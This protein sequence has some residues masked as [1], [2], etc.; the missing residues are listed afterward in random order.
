[1][2]NKSLQILAFWVAIDYDIGVCY[3]A[4]IMLKRILA[5]MVAAF[6]VSQ[7]MAED[8]QLFFGVNL[9]SS[10]LSISPPLANT[11][12]ESTP[13]RKLLG[14]NST[15]TEYDS[16]ALL[17][18]SN[19][20]DSFLLINPIAGMSF[21]IT[22]RILLEGFVKLDATEKDF[23]IKKIGSTND[24]ILSRVSRELGI[25]GSILMRISKQYSIGP[26]LEANIIT[27]ISPLIS[28]TEKQDYTIVEVGL[29]SVYKIHQYF[30]IGITC[31]AALD[32]SFEVKDPAVTD[33]SDLTLNYKA[34]KASVSLRLTP[35]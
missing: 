27:S 19:T 13:L 5:S 12:A 7:V 10:L 32:Q 2:E 31:S 1:M 25:G 17:E 11:T 28:G 16:Q 15:A 14:G 4:D 3:G 8:P 29:Q 9:G 22:N 35:F 18:S 23:T 20:F 30:S 26:T 6:S 21:P 33:S 34:A 24:K